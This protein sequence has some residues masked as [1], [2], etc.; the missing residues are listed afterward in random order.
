MVSANDCNTIDYDVALFFLLGQAML[1]A[2]IA[3]WDAKRAYD[4]VRP[5]SAIRYYFQGQTITAWLGEGQ[6]AGSVAGEAWRPY[7]RTTSA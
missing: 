6:G 2:S 1:D 3:A 4:S 5:I 7:Q